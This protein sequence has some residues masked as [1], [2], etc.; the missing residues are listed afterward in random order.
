[1]AHKRAGTS[2]QK[3]WGKTHPNP[4]Q[5]TRDGCTNEKTSN[6]PWCLKCLAE[7]NRDYR[8]TVM[9]MAERRGFAKGRET[10]RSMLAAEFDRLARA[11]FTGAEVAFAIRNAP[12]PGIESSVSVE[13]LKGAAVGNESPDRGQSVAPGLSGPGERD[14]GSAGDDSQTASGANT[15]VSDAG[16]A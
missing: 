9:D 15:G 7:Y 16:N 11:T 3:P 5:C 4:N 10:M 12:A 6:K 2:P 13:D 8:G 1:M 14:G